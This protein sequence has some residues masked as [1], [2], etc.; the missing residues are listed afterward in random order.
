MT[1]G[2]WKRSILVPL[3]PFPRFRFRQNV[4]ISLVAIPPTHLEAVDKNNRFRYQN[5]A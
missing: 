1:A 5:P 3:L 4:V 2:F